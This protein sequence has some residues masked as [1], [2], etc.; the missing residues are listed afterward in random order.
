[1]KFIVSF[2]LALSLIHAAYAQTPP[3]RA[4]GSYSGSLEG[5][6][7]AAKAIASKSLYDMMKNPVFAKKFRETF[8]PYTQLRWINNPQLDS[9]ARIEQNKEVG[10]IMIYTLCRPHWCGYDYARFIV[11]SDLSAAWGQVTIDT[12]TLGE[13][14]VDTLEAI[15]NDLK[16]RD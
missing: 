1:M 3:T 11:T 10:E 12:R 6:S 9:L 14:S 8:V 13:G 2:L 15:F 5:A 4:L 16:V 7:P